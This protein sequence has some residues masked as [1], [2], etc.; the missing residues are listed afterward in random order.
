MNT[1]KIRFPRKITSLFRKGGTLA[2]LASVLILFPMIAYS[3]TV[4]LAW[5]ANTEPDLAGYKIHYGTASHDYSRSIDV[6]ISPNIRSQILTMTLPI[7]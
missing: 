5:D 3:A 7:I 4:T 2:V 1:K 6:V